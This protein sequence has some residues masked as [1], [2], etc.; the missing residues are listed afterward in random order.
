MTPGPVLALDVGTRTIGVA[1]TDPGRRIVTPDR[2]IQRRSVAKDTEVIAAICQQ[3]RI[4]RVVVGLPLG[5]DGEE[6]R[7]ARLARQIAEAV[8]TRTG[9]P[10]DLHDE[11]F[12]TVEAHWRL[13]DA[14][15]GGTRRKAAIDQVAAV[16]ILE[17][18]LAAKARATPG[19]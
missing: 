9:L 4:V 8:A 5:L 7:S 18:W 15:V 16:V 10:V 2:T 19:E 17:D 1:A 6:G 11:R 3:R 14:D 12:S 13:S